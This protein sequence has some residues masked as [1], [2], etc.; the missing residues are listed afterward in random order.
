MHMPLPQKVN[1]RLCEQKYR[2]IMEKLSLPL[3]PSCI[4]IFVKGLVIVD[5]LIKC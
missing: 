5:V 2:V 3:D 1:H 4:Q